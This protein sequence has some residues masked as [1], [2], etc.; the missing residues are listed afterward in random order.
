MSGRRSTVGPAAACAATCA[1]GADS[2]LSL[3]TSAAGPV[4]FAE[5]GVAMAAALAGTGRSAG[6]VLTGVLA[7]TS[8]GLAA[9]FT[10]DAAFLAATA[11]DA[12]LAGTGGAARRGAA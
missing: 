12:A 4:A 1:R 5:A 9:V 6:C 7:A 8:A 11:P 3:T 10:G 2:G